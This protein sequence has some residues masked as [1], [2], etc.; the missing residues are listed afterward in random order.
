[1]K[2]N[3]I[4]LPIMTLVGVLCLSLGIYM[5]F[6]QSPSPQVQATV[7]QSQSNQVPQTPSI[8]VPANQIWTDTG[9]VL[10]RGQKVRITATGLVNIGSPNDAA[11]KWVGPEGWGGLPQFHDTTGAPHRYV[12]ETGSLGAL[13][14]KVGNS[15]PFKLGAN[16][17]FVSPDSGVLFVGV[18]DTVDP[19]FYSDNRGRFSIKVDVF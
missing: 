16:Y 19:L 9:I 5:R 13:R 15:R 1:M 3:S 12:Y 8:E 7:S 14:A 17:S 6:F 4:F 2:R 11:D 18:E 10:S